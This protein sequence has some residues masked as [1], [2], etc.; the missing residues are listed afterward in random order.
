MFPWSPFPFIRYAIA[1]IVGI[2]LNRQV[3]FPIDTLFLALSSFFLV[4]IIW[5]INC[6]N[7]KLLSLRLLAGIAVLIAFVIM[8]YYI[9]E[10]HSHKDRPGHY[11]SF[12]Q[13]EAFEAVVISDNS[14]RKDYQ[15]Y[16]VEIDKIYADDQAFESFGK[17]FLYVRKANSTAIYKYGDRL[18]VAARYHPIGPPGN[19]EEFDYR[20]YL[21]KQ[22]IFCHAFA[23]ESD[24]ALITNDP[25]STLISWGYAI[26]RKSK[27]VIFDF[28]P[29]LREQAIL[30][31]LLLGIKDHLD[32]ETK[33]AYSSAGA[34]HVLAVSG[35]HVGIIY[36]LINILLGFIKKKKAGKLAFIFL[37]IGLIWAY[38]LVTG[39]SPSVLRASVMFSVILI[40]QT[41]S[42]SANIY[43]SLG[44][45]A[46]V[47]L[48]YDPFLIYSVGFQLSFAAVFGIVFLQPKLARILSP[49]GKLLSYLWSITCVSIS[50]QLATFPLT[51]Y[52]FHQFPT[53]FLVSNIVVIP[54]AVVILVGGIALILGSFLHSWIA[55]VIGYGSFGIIW[56][57]NEAVGL[58]T[59]L[60][61]PIVD[62][63]YFDLYDTLLVY[64]II[65]L[66]SLAFNYE[67]KNALFLG[68]LTTL[69][70]ASWINWK[71]AMYSNQRKIIF[72]EIKDHIAIDL[73]DGKSAMLLVDKMDSS[74]IEVIGFQVNPF[75][76]ANGL[77]RME[78]SNQTFDDSDLIVK[79]SYGAHIHW[80][81]ISILLLGKDHDLQ[82]MEPINADVVY[83]SGTYIDNI[84]NIHGNMIVL[85][86]EIQYNR[87]KYIREKFESFGK[88]SHSLAEQGFYEIK[89]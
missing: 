15:R 59:L 51:V 10:L 53:Y 56:I 74:E 42:K 52:Y 18:S 7:R 84:E 62:W 35:L 87:L 6:F 67:L 37:A 71:L 13:A 43:N 28:I 20:A 34:M 80:N 86:A 3:I 5:L 77:P 25:P 23:S 2:L 40:S 22:N 11:T 21:E 47:L 8:G 55:A 78:N 16:E 76:L 38:A 81:D 61:L 75:R 83:V 30:T 14:E 9:S 46:F 82:I 1:L 49:N 4:S 33:E 65:L 12:A 45:A 79:S 69:V 89:M 17:I 68:L 54:A 66:I 57:V 44:I 41:L 24:I 31:A 39:F 29:E 48:L 63:L 36:Y 27:Q 26:R 88:K 60:P 73:I 19:P 32:N 58:L 64:A 85:G 50:A 72:Y 70:F